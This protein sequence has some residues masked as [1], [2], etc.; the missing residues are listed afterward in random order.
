M[1]YRWRKWL[2]KQTVRNCT[3]MRIKSIDNIYLTINLIS[4]L[5]LKIFM[6][7]ISFYIDCSNVL[8]KLKYNFTL[9][10]KQCYYILS[11]LVLN[12]YRVCCSLS[13]NN[14][15]RS[16]FFFCF[17]CFISRLSMSKTFMNLDKKKQNKKQP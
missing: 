14:Y 12:L 17:F 15:N 10:N 16:F 4:A 9:R 3:L 13:S 6:Y 2:F 5:C 7:N 1:V 11:F 8:F